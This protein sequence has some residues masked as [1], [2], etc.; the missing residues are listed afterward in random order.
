MSIKNSIHLFSFISYI[1]FGL[2]PII[3]SCNHNI[4][5]V[6]NSEPSNKLELDKNVHLSSSY[7]EVKVDLGENLER[8][9]EFE[10]RDL[11]SRN[12]IDADNLKIK[13][14]I[15]SEIVGACYVEN[16]YP[17]IWS[18]EDEN[19]IQYIYLFN[20]GKEYK[21]DLK[22]EDGKTIYLSRV[23]TPY[24]EI[25]SWFAPIS[26]EMILS[27]IDKLPANYKEK[28]KSEGSYELE[29]WNVEANKWKKKVSHYKQGDFKFYPSEFDISPYESNL[30]VT[31][32]GKDGKIYTKVFKNYV[33]V[34]N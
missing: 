18:D 9:D 31:I 7:D 6:G 27:S 8:F 22:V 29:N 5:E 17:T 34:G 4:K 1:F 21:K 2:V 16:Y 33:I 10:A 11:L 12:Y 3:L 15:E 30:I 26:K 13:F 25:E 14:D 23:S 28:E 32:K 20:L 19:L 24:E